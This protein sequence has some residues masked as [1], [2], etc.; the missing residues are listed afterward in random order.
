M[1]LILLLPFFSGCNSKEQEVFTRTNIA[2][3]TIATISIYDNGS[4]TLLDE[5]FQRLSEIDLMMSRTNEDSI[6]S[7]IN[8]AYGQTV[9]VEEE[10]FVVI[11]KALHYGD[12][13]NGIFDITLAPI[14]DLW[15]IGTETPYVPTSKEVEDLLELV[16]YNQVKLDYQ[17]M[18]VKIPPKT[19][20]DLGGIA[21]GY[22]ADEIVEILST[23]GVTSAYVNIGG[24]VK[25]L[26]SK[27][28]GSRFRV[29]VQDPDNLTG[30]YF[31]ILS[32]VDKTI[33]TS[34]D[35]ER[36]ITVDGKNYHHIFSARTGFPVDNELS[37][38]SIITDSSIDA[39]ALSTILYAK[40][41]DD[42]MRFAKRLNGVDVI[43]VTHDK[44]VYLSNPD[45]TTYFEIVDDEFTI[46]E[47]TAN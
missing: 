29:G 24:N 23:S 46:K 14:V 2:M 30:V 38:V 22:A 32:V 42:G 9:E 7:K 26:G 10:V 33:V 36:F 5:C 6:V 28:D 39:D 1:S 41:L 4:E 12:I 15:G 3:G 20:V 34:G 45:M 27:L 40:G 47:H 44:E 43:F 37:A 17:N 13:S 31:G 11:E 35:Y 18:S 19:G 21:K 25:L 16:D 8:R